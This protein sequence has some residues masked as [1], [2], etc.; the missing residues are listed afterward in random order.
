MG[1]EQKLLNSFKQRIHCAI[2]P[3]QSLPV[4]MPLLH[5]PQQ[6]DEYVLL[7]FLVLHL[8]FLLDQILQQYHH[9]VVELWSHLFSALLQMPP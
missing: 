6:L 3:V 5:L 2:M 4:Q 8:S 7:A 9:V 1:R